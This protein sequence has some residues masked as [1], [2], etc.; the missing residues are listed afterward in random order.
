MTRGFCSLAGCLVL[1]AVSADSAQALPVNR[2]AAGPPQTVPGPCNQGSPPNF[3]LQSTIA[4]ASTRDHLSDRLSA[5]EGSEI[6]LM[7][8]TGT[9]VRRLTDNTVGDAF[10][11][12][13][14]DGKRIV[15]DSDR[16]SGEFNV[17]D[18]FLMDADGGQQTFLTHGSSATWSPDCKEI[19]FHASASGDGTPTR[20]DPGAATIDS[21]IF[22][23]NVDD[24]LASVAEPRD[25]TNTADLIED[26][27]DW[28]PDG[29]HIAYTAHLVGD[30]IPN[31]AGF[32]SNTAEIYVI[33]SDGTGG[34]TQLTHDSFEERSVAWSPDGSRLAFS[35]RTDGGKTVFH[36]CIMNADG[37]GYTRLTGNDPGGDLTP[38]WSPHG[39]QILFHRAVPLQGLQLFTITPAL[40]PD[41][42]Y[43]EEVQVTSPPGINLLAH[44]GVLR[45]K[46]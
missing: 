33:N 27:A 35:C 30:D 18:V 4:F 9:D 26:D 43:P 8:S 19:A 34:P 2:N 22:V 20:T 24:L 37:T 36:I 44:W 40:N 14:P 6:Y 10:A 23:A 39:T 13:S 25:I 32:L 12:L 7:S 1:L 41:L 5:P 45:V 3:Q 21:D 46:G 15:F 31:G 38:S 29:R 28:S 17:S 16:L 11:N 42:T